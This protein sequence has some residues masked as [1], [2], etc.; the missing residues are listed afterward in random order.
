MFRGN[1]FVLSGPSGVGKD[2]ILERILKIV[3]NLVKSVSYTTRPKR[4][5]EENG[6]NY[7]F[8][9]EKKFKEMIENGEF[10]EWA[11]V[12][13]Y[14]YGTPKKMV[15]DYIK[16]GMDVILKID[17]QGGVNVK[18]IYNEAKLIFVLPPDFNELKRRLISRETESLEDLNLRLRNAPLEI[19]KISYYDYAIVNDNLDEAVDM[20]RCI[21]YAER[22]RLCKEKIEYFLNIFG[23]AKD[24]R[25]RY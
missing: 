12:H 20:V 17:V 23:G 14:L 3:P 4:P 7:F 11:V 2:A 1:L 22:H 6:K 10:L 5:S 9:D 19:S 18:K 16:R 24:E 13:G 21:I 15:E 25:D 8:V